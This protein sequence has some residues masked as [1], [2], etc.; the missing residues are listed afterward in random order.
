MHG[1]NKKKLTEALFALL[2][3]MVEGTRSRCYG[4]TA[5]LRLI[6]QLCD[7]DE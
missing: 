3:F 4:R 5:A 6:V 1:M 7:E 2:F